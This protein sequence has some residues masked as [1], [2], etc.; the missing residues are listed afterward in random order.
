MEQHN[1][2]F[3]DLSQEQ[4]DLSQK[5]ELNAVDSRVKLSVDVALHGKPKRYM[6]LIL[7]LHTIINSCNS[8]QVTCIFLID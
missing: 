2:R 7:Q 5:S 4:T 1:Q 6:K 3:L 8:G